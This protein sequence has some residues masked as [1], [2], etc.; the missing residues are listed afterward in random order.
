RATDGK[1]LWRA[2]N[3]KR[4]VAVIPT[5]IVAGSRVFFTSGYGAGSELLDLAVAEDGTAT[6]KAVY[7][8]NKLMVNQH[9]G[10]VRIGEYAYGYTD[11]GGKWI[12]FEFLKG[13]E[14]PVWESKA[15]DKGS[16]IAA[17]GHLYCFG[18]S[19]GT[20]VL[21][22]ARPDGWKE[23]GRLELPAKSAFPRGQGAI[24]AHPVVANGKLYLRD[25]E[26]LFCF[27]IAAK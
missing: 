10:V 23:T 18:Q 6:A 14:D 11:S 25:H 9:G 19:K 3:L 16:L 20:C 22:E 24:W 17:D 5:P 27:D 15:L 7:G 2:T 12:C 21:V 4:A 1:L 13:A 26:L 8:P